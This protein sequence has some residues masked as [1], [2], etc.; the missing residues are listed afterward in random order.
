MYNWY[1][2]VEIC[3]TYL[4]DIYQLDKPCSHSVWFSRVWTLQELLTPTVVE[5]YSH[6][7]EYIGTK[8][9]L[10]EEIQRATG[11]EK[12]FFLNH[13]HIKSASVGTK[14]SWAAHRKNTRPVDVAY[15]L[16]G[17]LKSICQCCTGKASE[18]SIDFK[19]KY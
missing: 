12:R 10:A 8:S 19:C 18:R 3:C 11:M 4:S 15:I 17:I 13:S 14:F 2:K 1:W 6:N 5:F 9:S 16:L 7:W